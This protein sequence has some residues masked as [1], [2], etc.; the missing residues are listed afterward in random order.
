M[1]KFIYIPCHAGTT[2]LQDLLSK[3]KNTFLQDLELERI[4]MATKPQWCDMRR[5]LLSQVAARLELIDL[6]RFLAVCKG[7]LRAASY[8]T[9]TV[10]AEVGSHIPWFLVY[11]GSRCASSPN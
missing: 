9:A 8:N 7:F 6:L 10:T 11:G 5:E 3:K 1:Y 4:D 2:L